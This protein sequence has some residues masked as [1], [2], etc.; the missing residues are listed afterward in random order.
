MLVFDEFLILLLT[1]LSSKQPYIKKAV[2]WC[3]TDP[4]LEPVGLGGE[5]KQMERVEE[6]SAVQEEEEE[7]D[8]Y[9]WEP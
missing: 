4:D 5:A 8:K 1:D 7:E 2:C 9:Y 3:T 6:A